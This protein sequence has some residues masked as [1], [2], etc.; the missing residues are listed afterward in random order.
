MKSNKLAKD[1][2]SR[3]KIDAAEKFVENLKPTSPSK[4]LKDFMLL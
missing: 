2:V 1:R 3:Y 4:G